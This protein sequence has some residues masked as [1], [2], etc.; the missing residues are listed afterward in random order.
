[1]I[2]IF[3]DTALPIYSWILFEMCRWLEKIA[4]AAYTKARWERFDL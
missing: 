3:M 1:M 4:E 2:P